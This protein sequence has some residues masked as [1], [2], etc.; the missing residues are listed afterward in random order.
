MFVK[1]HSVL[2]GHRKTGKLIIPIQKGDMSEC[3]NYRSISLLGLP[4][5][6]YAKLVKKGKAKN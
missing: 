6:V 2:E 3:T 1:C 4:G 5:K